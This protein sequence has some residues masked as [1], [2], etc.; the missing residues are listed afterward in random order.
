MENL[1]EDYI[2]ELFMPEGERSSSNSNNSSTI[3]NKISQWRFFD[4]LGISPCE[5]D[6]CRKTIE[7][8]TIIIQ[9]MF[10]W[11]DQC[12]DLLANE[13]LQV[14]NAK[15]RFEDLHSLPEEIEL[16]DS[17]Q[18]SLKKIE[19]SFLR[20]PKESD[21]ED[22]FTSQMRTLSN[23]IE[24]LSENYKVTISMEGSSMIAYLMNYLP[25]G[26]DLNIIEEDQKNSFTIEHG[27]L[28][29]CIFGDYYKMTAK[30]LDVYISDSEECFKETGYMIVENNKA[31]KVISFRDF[32]VSKISREEINH[33]LRSILK[34][35]E[36][37]TMALLNEAIAISID[38]LEEENY[39]R[40]EILKHLDISYISRCDL[41]LDVDGNEEEEDNQI[42]K[43]RRFFRNENINNG[44]VILELFSISGDIFKK[45]IDFL[46][47]FPNAY[48]YLSSEVLSDFQRKRNKKKK[49]RLISLM[50]R[51]G[52][53]HIISLK[54]Q[55]SSDSD[56]T[57]EATISTTY[58]ESVG[59]EI[60]DFFSFKM[61]ENS[62][63]DD[64]SDEEDYSD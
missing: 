24:N 47:F 46:K 10:D 22:T 16:S 15:I 34:H 48:L 51:E 1:K 57:H 27:N 7:D 28:Y 42:N 59:N 3:I 23:L 49:E 41:Y 12:Q 11:G 56:V 14:I 39:N 63:E 31:N 62:S 6:W 43:Y 52:F 9:G 53:P 35:S 4:T 18:K 44:T 8:D 33:S 32:K 5:E 17:L 21:D 19:L 36:E 2:F 50:A 20:G 60:K 64:S 37:G 58:S 25:R 26:I 38:M 13:N 45:A 29:Y 40:L 55:S 54:T 30:Q 61:E